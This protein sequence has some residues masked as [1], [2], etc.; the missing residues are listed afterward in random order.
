GCHEI[1]SLS[2]TFVDKTPVGASVTRGLAI[3]LAS[4]SGHLV[5]GLL[6]GPLTAAYPVQVTLGSF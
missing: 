6:D 3:C 1:I 2:G 5:G 4:S